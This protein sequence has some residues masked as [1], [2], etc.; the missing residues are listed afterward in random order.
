[1]PLPVDI[2]YRGLPPSP[3]LSA[4]IRERAGHLAHFAPRLLACRVTVRMSEH[5]HHKGNRFLVTA[6]AT[7]P[8]GAFHAGRTCA[9]DRAH[10]DAYVAASDAIDALRR[11]L[12][13]FR[14]LRLDRAQ[15]PGHA[16]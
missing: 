6:H 3:A 8:G 12:A 7:M 15:A 14:T 2:T 11:Q 10:E 5:R 4:H 16:G 1:M 13:D 9:G